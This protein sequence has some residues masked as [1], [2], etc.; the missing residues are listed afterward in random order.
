MY[1]VCATFG[2]AAWAG[3]SCW[4]PG[5]CGI[6]AAVIG[7]EM[8]TDSKLECVQH[9]KQMRAA[10]AQHG[11][12]GRPRS[13]L[14]RP[15]NCLENLI[16]GDI[17]PGIVL[18]T[19]HA[20]L[21]AI[22]PPCE[23]RGACSGSSMSAEVH[24]HSKQACALHCQKNRSALAQ[25]GAWQNPHSCICKV[26]DCLEKPIPGSEHP[27]VVLS[28]S[29]QCLGNAVAPPCWGVN[30][31]KCL[32]ADLVQEGNYMQGM[33]SI[34]DLEVNLKHVP[35]GLPIISASALALTFAGALVF[36]MRR[37]NWERESLGD[38]EDCIE[39]QARFL[40]SS[41]S[42]LGASKRKKELRCT[43]VHAQ[44]A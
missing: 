14:C 44:R 9:C 33:I 10:V 11:S 29:H 22:Q 28:T 39:S 43:D 23:T 15:A 21:G 25:Y 19:A 34:F 16:P 17:H 24:M 41:K 18:S 7:E 42:D 37:H 3:T 26:A 12:Y 20:C 5:G 36:G 35:V 27:G 31:T 40:T 32:E 13:C 2:Q 30:Q 4:I 6:K 8:F 1:F 38:F